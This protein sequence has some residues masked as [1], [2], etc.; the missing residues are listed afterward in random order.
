[1][2]EEWTS[3]WNIIILIFL[4]K[5]ILIGGNNQKRTNPSYIAWNLI[6][7]MQYHHSPTINNNEK[8]FIYLLKI[9]NLES[10]N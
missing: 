7:S 4:E 1:M 3:Y 2:L 10:W 5:I 6:I 9:R 8:L